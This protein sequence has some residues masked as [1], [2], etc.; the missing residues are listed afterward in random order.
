MNKYVEVLFNARGQHDILA[1]YSPEWGYPAFRDAPFKFAY[2]AQ[3]KCNWFIYSDHFMSDV[4]KND[5]IN[6][7][8]IGD[9]LWKEFDMS[10]A[11]NPISQRKPAMSKKGRK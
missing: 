4:V 8:T 2:K 1:E 9:L 6:R 11:D 7:L 10:I 5:V 3:D